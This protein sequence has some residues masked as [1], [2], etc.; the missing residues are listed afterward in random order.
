MAKTYARFTASPIGPALTIQNGGLIL[1]TNAATADSARTAISDV[2][3]STDAHG[4]EFVVW[5]DDALTCDIG[6]A[7]TGAA[8]GAALGSIAGSLAWALHGGAIYSGGTA[9]ATGLPAVNKGDIVGVSVDLAASTATFW[10]NGE[11]VHSRALPST[12]T[13]WHFGASLHTPGGA[14]KLA[15]AVNAG[16]WQRRSASVPVWRAAGA[17]IA[18]TRLADADWLAATTDTPAHARYEGVIDPRSLT[19]Q[20]EIGFWP[21]G[22]DAPTGAGA[23]TLTAIDP[24]G[25]LDALAQEDVAGIEVA[26]ASVDPDGTPTR[27]NAIRCNDAST[28]VVGVIGSGGALPTGWTIGSYAGITRE[29]VAEGAL[30]DGTPYVDIRISGTNS[31]TATIY[32]DLYFDSQ[33]ANA[34]AKIGETWTASAYIQHIAGSESTG[35][36]SAGPRRLSI[37]EVSSTGAWLVSTAEPSTSNATL[38]RATVTR[39]TNNATL[40]AVRAFI[41]FAVAAGGTVDVTMRIAA[42][43]LERSPEATAVITTTGTPVTVPGTATRDGASAVARFALD[44]IEASDDMRKT[45]FLRDAHDDLDE[46]VARGVFLPSVPALAWQPQPVV[47]GAVASV[48]CLRANSDGSVLWLADT[49]LAEVAA[50]YDRGDVMEPSTVAW[51]PGPQQQLTCTQPTIGPVLADVSSIGA[52]MAPATLVQTLEA[53]LRRIGK[54]SWSREDAQAIDTATGYAGIGFYDDGSATIREALAALLPSWGAWLWQD[55]AGLLRFARVADPS[56]GT[57]AFDLDA[58][59]FGE[60]IVARSDDAPNLSRRMLYRPNARVMQAG[61]FVTDLVDVPPSLREQ[62]GQSH[63]GQVYAAAP[64]A[65]RYAHA[66]A[67]APKRSHLWREQDAQAEIDRVCALY[68]V[69]RSLYLVRVEGMDT[70]PRPGQVGRITYA[71]HGLSNG[72]RVLV[73]RVEHVPA[74]GTV[75]LTLWG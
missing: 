48:P 24:D 72:K 58:S 8:L 6:L 32:P 38:R 34:A 53:L 2:S 14:G 59:H 74:T 50:V 69:P 36:T 12:G 62:M 61:E 33:F 54:G 22:G 43:Q 60:A 25:V 35:F 10:H 7:P 27:R 17:A 23:A 39:T 66:D 65:P 19:L 47:I 11:S 9:L 41:S 42:P 16:Q 71:R 51:A 68:A 44:R 55:A 49:A 75:T 37:S 57:L 5:G 4:V 18:T 29:V 15:L 26:I 40:Y 67:A 28:A 1:T 64:L 56:A 70:P 52:G 73:R 30:A 45:L 63:R 31:G 46:P 3:H 13:T 20:A 21:W